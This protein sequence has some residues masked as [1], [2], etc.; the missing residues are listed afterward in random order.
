MQRFVDDVST[1]NRV[2]GAT[3]YGSLRELISDAGTLKLRINLCTEECGEMTKAWAELKNRGVADV[4]ELK[5]EVL[6]GLGDLVYVAAGLADVAAI[7]L[8]GT[9][10]APSTPKGDLETA[11]DSGLDQDCA[12][13]VEATLDQLIN[14]LDIARDALETCPDLYGSSQDVVRYAIALLIR[15]CAEMANACGWDLDAAFDLIH[16]SNMSKICRD[17]E[18]AQRTV[19]NY[20]ATEDKHPYRDVAYRAGDTGIGAGEY[21]VVYDGNGKILKSIDY[22]PVDLSKLV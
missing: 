15:R 10:D 1:F 12:A 19:A 2:M 21:F 6:D 18:T 9:V 8:V 14:L 4:P 16:A 11:L 3:R 13:K 7:S 5:A 17:E 22:A 20:V